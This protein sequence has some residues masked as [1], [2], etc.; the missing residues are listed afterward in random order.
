MRF[1]YPLR[2]SSANRRTARCSQRRRRPALEALDDRILL[3]GEMGGAWLDLNGDGANEIDRPPLAGGEYGPARAAGGGFTILTLNESPVVVEPLPDLSVDEDAPNTLL[4]LGPVFTD[5]DIGRG[6]ALTYTATVSMPIDS[7]VAQVSQSSYTTLHQDLLYTHTGDNRGVA[8][9]EHDLARD[10]IYSYFA[11]LGLDTSLE[12]FVYS[13]K[14][15]YN[16][17]GVYPGVTEPGAIYLVGAHYDSVDN[18]GADDNASGVAAVMELAR[19]L[20]QYEFDATL[21]FVAFDREEQGLYGSK[22]YANAHATDNILGMVSLDMIAYNIPGT[23]HDTVRFYDYI[24]GGVIKSQLAAAFA[25]YGGGLATVDS[26]QEYGSDHSPFEQKGFDAALVIEYAV[27][28]N[29]YYHRAGDAVETANYID[30]VYATKVTRGVM[31]YL[32]TAAGLVSPSDLMTVTVNGRD[33]TLDYAAD[34]HGIADIAVRATDALGLYAEDTFR[35]TVTPVN[36]APELDPTGVM[37]LWAIDEDT[38]VNPG[39]L[40]R[41]IVASGGNDRIT[42]VDYG[43]LEGMAVT[44]VDNT[45]G[46]WQYTVNAGRTWNAF[47]APTA[48]AARLLGSDAGTRIRFLPH[49]D[50]NGTVD[51]GLTFRA[52]DHTQGFNGQT[53]DASV[54]GGATAFSAASESAA[55][56]VHPVNDPPTLSLANTV[57]TLPESTPT[58]SRIKVADVVVT[59]DGQGVNDLKTSGPDAALFEID[60]AVLYLKAGAVLDFETNPVLDVTVEVDDATVGPTPDDTA[61]LAI[62]VTDVAETLIVSQFTWTPAGFVAEFSRAL[63]PSTLNLYDGAGGELGPADVLLQD[64]S[65][66]AVAGSIVVDASRQQL[67]FVPAGSLLTPDV[68]TVTLKSGEMAFRDLAASVLDGDGDW[69]PGGDFTTQF[70]VTSSAD[71]TVSIPDVAR[72]A[73]QP[74]NV[75]NTATGL[76]LRLD[77]AD[78]VTSLAVDLVHDRELLQITA[79]T[80]AAG[81]PGDWSVTSPPDTSTPGVAKIW[82]SGTTPLSGTN[83]DVLRLTATVPDTA[84]YGAV[85]AIRL[86]NVSLNGGAI[87]ARGDVAV[88][89]AVYLGDADGSGIHSSADAFLTVQAALGLASGFAANAWTDPLIVG[90]ADGSGVLSAADAFLIVQEGLGL[91]ESFVPDNPGIGVTLVGGGV[92]PQFRIG[93][94]LPAV[95]G[96]LV[97]VPVKLD[98]EPAATNVGGIDFDLFFDPSQ[99]AI[100]LPGGV[101]TGADTASGWSIFSRLIDS[102]HLRVGL[103]SSSGRPLATGLREIAQLVFRVEAGATVDA[104][105]RDAIPL[106]ERAAY[107]GAIPASESPDYVL[108]LDIEPVD[109]SAGG[110]AWTASDGS[111]LIVPAPPALV[112]S[113]I[114]YNPASLE[115][116]WEWVEVYNPGPVS[117]DLAGYVLDDNNT[118][119]LPASN[120]ASGRVS[121]RGTAVLFNADAIGAEDFRAAWGADVNLVP[122]TGWNVL[123][124]GNSGDRVGL[125]R[126]FVNY[127]GDH[128]NHNNTVDDVAFDDDGVIWPLDDGAASIYL[129]NVSVD[130]N[131]GEN[132]ALSQA[133]TAGA[134]Q[135]VAAGGNEGGDIG[136]PGFAPN[137]WHN[138]A[139]P[140][141]VTGDGAVT[142]DDV[143]AGVNYLNSEASDRGLPLVQVVPPR[144]Y[145]VSTDR[146]CTPLDILMVIAYLNLQAQP[147]A[148]G[149]PS[150]LATATAAAGVWLERPPAPPAPAAAVGRAT[151]VNARI[152]VGPEA[153]KVRGVEFPS[154]CDVQRGRFEAVADALQR[155]LHDLQPEWAALEPVLAEIAGDIAGAWR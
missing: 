136:S 103:L 100:Q 102:G 141:D 2:R 91:D 10:N 78:G 108:P 40:V 66:K 72:G 13:S 98:V 34:K 73:G 115:P 143:L 145:D 25:A 62:A 52:W 47:G 134:W 92:D 95:A 43:A 97:S 106:A 80:L 113:E 117:V 16:V 12:S 112:I 67:T 120:I 154:A 118:T 124:L 31:G 151:D 1:K 35:V 88:H 60:G 11:S 84:P 27:R 155:R 153:P 71:R 89:K 107:G 152:V 114:M 135:S 48:V 81:L 142:A 15:Y 63:D 94:N 139:N 131:A 70:T 44:A 119:A 22:A 29:P 39:T 129:V 75:P 8:G 110:Y 36:D 121:A 51:P 69:T 104:P 56:T 86:E 125:W 87:A 26:G 148:E 126:D 83:V 45:H 30:Y 6:D 33:L 21:V 149:E 46:A 127:R 41:D 20:T 133:G 138:L 93:E 68:Y 130:N 7:L 18:P 64:G 9:W 14:T 79:A 54:G 90:D 17:V 28:D 122:V 49:A 37:T 137:I 76:P 85:Q 50:W 82:A 140:F 59:D 146:A 24:R 4:D 42:D 144:Y 96:S 150:G 61:D 74:V 65:G 109:P 53:A 128:V 58:G 116:D 132:W 3:T 105:L 101:L 77:N 38:T 5:P 147:K 19:V 57:A 99:L 32:A 55:I 123:S 23:G 111:L